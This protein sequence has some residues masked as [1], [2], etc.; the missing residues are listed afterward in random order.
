[1]LAAVESRLEGYVTRDLREHKSSNEEW[2]T[3]PGRIGLA[4]AGL[5]LCGGEVRFHTR[6]MEFSTRRWWLM[7]YCDD[8]V[9]YDHLATG[10]APP[11]MAV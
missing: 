2:G 7:N 9:A 10:R 5:A 1:M 4:R 11:S 6:P 8:S 3:G